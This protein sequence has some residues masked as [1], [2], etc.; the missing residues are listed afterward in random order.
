MKGRK[1][2]KKKECRNEAYFFMRLEY[3][4]SGLDGWRFSQQQKI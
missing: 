2:D 4:M 3:V 1:R